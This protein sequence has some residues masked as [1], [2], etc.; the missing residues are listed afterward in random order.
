MKTRK[1]RFAN[2]DGYELS[3]EL[4]LPTGAE[5]HHFALFA[6]CFTC[7]KNLLAVKRLSKALT[8]KGFG[9]FKFDFTGLGQ[10]DGDFSDTNFSGN[11][12]DLISA[13][14]YLSDHYSSPSLLIGHSLGGAAVL[15]AAQYINDLEGIITI[16]APYDP[17]HVQNLFNDW[18]EEILSKGEATVILAGRKFTIKKQFLEDLRSD[19]VNP[20]LQELNLPL[21]ILHSP[22]DQTVGIENAAQIYKHAKHPKSFISLDG[23]DHLMTARKDANYAG[24]II[25]EW[26]TRYIG[27]DDKQTDNKETKKHAIAELHMEDTFTTDVQTGTHRWV[28]DEPK[29]VGGANLGPS[30]GQLL[31]SALATCS[32]MTVMMYVRRKKWPLQCIRV[33]V[34]KKQTDKAIPHATYIKQ[35]KLIGPELTDKQRTRCL[36]IAAKCPIHRTLSVASEIQSSL[37]DE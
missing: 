5:A 26:A 11:I 7:S 34:H 18:E 1:I 3:A 32:A 37:L 27:G 13:A 16:G 30:P 31:M 33:F 14:N 2:A 15:Q 9:V 36:E 4:D 10:S 20:R 8:D 29:D 22:Q 6:H 17:T 25:A 21:L 24:R 23:S 35:V 28:A 19:R 12:E